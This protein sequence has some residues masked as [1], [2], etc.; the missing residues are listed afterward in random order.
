MPKRQRWQP[1]RGTG[2]RIYEPWERWLVGAADLPFRAAAGTWRLLVRP[3]AIDPSAV[4][5]VLVLRLDRIGDVV[6]SL[7]A[8][9]DLRAALPSAHITLAVGRWSEDVARSAPVDERLIWNAPWVG[10]PA[11]GSVPMGTLLRE[12]WARRGSKPDLAFDLQGDVRAALLMRA[13]GARHRVGYANTGGGALLT[14]VVPLDETVSWVEQNRRAVALALGR[15]PAETK[16]A[17]PLNEADRDFAERLFGTLALG[18]R[19]PVVVIHPSGGRLVKQWELA[20]WAEVGGQLQRQFGAA[21]LLSGAAGDGPLAAEVARGL[22][23]RAYDL[24]GKLSVRETMAV[25]AAADLFLSPDT[26]TM[27]MACA[28]GTP[29]V[30]V[31]GP[32]DPVRYFSGSAPRHVVVR[33]DLWCSPCNLIRKPPSE[34]AGA[35][36][37]EC[38]GLVSAAAVYEA[39]RRLLREVGGY[40]E[41]A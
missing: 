12:A 29:S 13:T 16:T 38:L 2:S 28:V 5:R 7:P 25:I 26:G 6:M 30:T 17:S 3:A 32:S 20:R 34:C 4:R 15:T 14:H 35:A 8:L 1:V 22:P 18:S 31:F 41:R 27:H 10:R 33:A 23:R 19:R 9:A 36:P 24:T 40:S 21:V 37:P 39:A 11:E